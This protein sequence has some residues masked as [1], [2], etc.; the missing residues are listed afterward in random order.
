MQYE[1]I[2][3]SKNR[4]RLLLPF[5]Y[6]MPSRGARKH[7]EISNPKEHC[8]GSIRND[9]ESNRAI[10]DELSDEVAQFKHI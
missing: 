1:N 3:R 2:S 7:T 10:S 9:A 4:T 8:A 5:V 6:S